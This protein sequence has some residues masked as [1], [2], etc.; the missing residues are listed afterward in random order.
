VVETLRVDVAIDTRPFEDVVADA[1][2]QQ[3]AQ[4]GDQ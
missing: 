2:A 4:Q 3:G 1:Q